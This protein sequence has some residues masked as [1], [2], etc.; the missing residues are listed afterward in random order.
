[1]RVSIITAHLE[2]SNYVEEYKKS[3]E[4][5]SFRDF[6]IILEEDDPAAP[7]GVAAMRNRALERA[8]ASGC[9]Y[10]FF[11]DSDDYL[12][13]E[14]LAEAVRT[15]KDNP[16]KAVRI[17]FT[18]TKYKYDTLKSVTDISALGKT[19]PVL[20]NVFYDS[21]LGHL[22]PFDAVKD[23]RFKEEL[24][25]FADFPYIAAVYSRLEV[26]AMDRP[27]YFKRVHND[28]ITY[29]SLDQKKIP[30]RLQDYAR[31]LRLTAAAMKDT[32]PLGRYIAKFAISRVIGN[33]IPKASRW[34]D[35]DV[36]SVCE[37]VRDYCKKVICEYS[38][39]Q[40]R[41]LKRMRRV[42]VKGVRRSIKEHYYSI[43]IG[44]FIRSRHQKRLVTYHRI[45]MKKPVDQNMVF[46]S[47]FYGRAYADSPRAIYEYMLKHYPDKK[48]VWLMNDDSVEIP[49]KPIR[50]HL[51]SVK[52]MYYCA[53]A[54]L[55]VTNT[56]Q[57][58]WYKKRPEA[59]LLQCWH[60]TP[61]KRLVFDL[62]DVF[63]AQPDD[64]KSFFYKQA[65]EWDWLISDNSFSTNAFNTA[66]KYPKEKMLEVGYPRNDL[67]F[68]DDR[69]ARAEALKKKLGLPLDKKLVLYAP[70]WRDDQARGNQ[71]Y[72]FD[73][74]FDLK[75]M[76]ELKDEYFFILRMHYFISDR[77]QLTD[78]EKTY[79]ADYSKY[80]D[81]GELYLISDVLITDYSSVF[82][83]YANLHRPML[84]YVYDLE[85]YRDTLH[86]FYFNMEEGCPGPMLTTN[87]QV[88]D[89]LKNIDRISEEYRDRYEKFCE[90]F[91]SLDDGRAA[92]RV[93]KAIM[94]ESR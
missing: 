18:W 21:C 69:E 37:L 40:K 2:C 11:M 91:C 77:L 72:G 35:N 81:I 31:S 89:A 32:A 66:F 27:L 29:P 12:D 20:P 51:D 65:C 26:V 73:M 39:E 46:F 25:I 3:L 30:T 57:P 5:Q 43:Q 64:Y 71:E 48:Y 70:T 36:V 13:P 24:K 9:D 78:E 15:A 62:A 94:Q 22:I 54:G 55:W 17:P 87:E 33:K 16:G 67:L 82:F 79:V 59:K 76:A 83:D 90:E 85:D 80:N 7:L 38:G 75:K 50:I 6:E 60:G 14:A 42:S 10:I 44:D 63:G 92:E 49:G 8:A 61:L 86:G 4:E 19:T 41:L 34:S 47:T 68:G 23:L 53:R 88:I 1:M 84:F 74:K 28:P 52:Y 93:V 56:R 58:D 45:F